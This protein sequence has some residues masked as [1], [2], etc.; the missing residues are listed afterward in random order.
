MDSTNSPGFPFPAMQPGEVID[1]T[2]A[3][4]RL[5]Y[6]LEWR[7]W[8]WRKPARELL[9]PFERFRGKRVLEI[10]GKSG[11]MSCLL[12]AT[13]AH[14]TAVD[15]WAEA[16]ER[17]R[18]EAMRWGVAD[19]IEFITYDGDGRKLPSGPF[20]VIFT[21]SV[22]VMI[23]RDHLDTM[24]VELKRRL[25]PSGLGLFIENSTNRLIEWC[26]HSILHRGDKS[27][28]LRHWGFGRDHLARI[29]QVF[30]PL[31]ISQHYRLVW[32]IRTANGDIAT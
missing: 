22:L 27:L 16:T 24:L 3:L 6:C 17:A 23:Y 2:E 8:L 15:V 25:A 10:G 26:R 20:D 14:V 11:R 32:T 7:P 12:A 19:R 29:E 31:Q 5:D 30:G 9:A 13:G 28:K 1:T 4:R 18:A 21:K